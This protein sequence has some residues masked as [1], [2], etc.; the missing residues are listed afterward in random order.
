MET[1]EMPTD[2][3]RIVLNQGG[4]FKIFRGT[5]AL[6]KYCIDSRL[7]IVGTESNKGNFVVTVKKA[8]SYI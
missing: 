2:C 8:D 7:E 4:M 5:H 1:L 6:Q 3:S